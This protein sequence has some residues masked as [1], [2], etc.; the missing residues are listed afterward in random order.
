MTRENAEARGRRY[1]VEG[2][3]IISCVD[4]DLVRATC[5]GSGDV[6][7]LGHDC[8]R[9]WWCSCPARTTCSHLHALGLVAIRRPR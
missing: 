2:R 6:H 9:G 8:A 5:R 4:G 7:D 1:L 3:L